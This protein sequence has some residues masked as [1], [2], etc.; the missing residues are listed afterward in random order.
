MRNGAYSSLETFES[1]SANARAFPARSDWGFV[2]IEAANSITADPIFDATTGPI[3]QPRTRTR[4]GRQ[5]LL[6]IGRRDTPAPVAR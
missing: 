3:K 2:K 1:A 5:P 4:E 6:C